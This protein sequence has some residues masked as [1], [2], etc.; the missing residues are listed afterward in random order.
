MHQIRFR[1]ELRPKPCWE[2][3]QRSPNPLARFKGPTFKGK[4][5]WEGEKEWREERE[6]KGGREEGKGKSGEGREANKRELHPKK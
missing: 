4:E 3:S 1:L 2:S 6:R 5:E